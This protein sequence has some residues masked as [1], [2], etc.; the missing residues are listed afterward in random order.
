MAGGRFELPMEPM[1]IGLDSLNS[2]SETHMTAT[3]DARL[4]YGRGWISRVFISCAALK[5]IY[6]E[7]QVIR[8]FSQK[9]PADLLSYDKI[10]S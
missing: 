8:G 1:A 5:G 3:C 6:P 9:I 4:I 2:N 7:F 10:Q